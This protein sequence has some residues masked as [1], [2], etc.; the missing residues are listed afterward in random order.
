MS[1]CVRKGL[2]SPFGCFQNHENIFCWAK[3][4]LFYRFL[5]TSS[6]FSAACVLR[7]R[8]TAQG[9]F[10]V[11]TSSLPKKFEKGDVWSFFILF[12]RFPAICSSQCLFGGH[13]IVSQGCFDVTEHVPN[14]ILVPKSFFLPLRVSKSRRKVNRGGLLVID[15]F[16][17]FFWKIIISED[18]HGPRRP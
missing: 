1:R 16:S 13:A 11:K 2:E 9:P 5:S 8:N 7:E 12:L 14:N 4:T 18:L 10:P 6:P 15:T 3:T 17:D